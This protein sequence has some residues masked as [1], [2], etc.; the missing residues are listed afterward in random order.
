MEENRVMS[1]SYTFLAREAIKRANRFAHQGRAECV[2]TLHMLLA[3]L[4]EDS[5]V[6][7]TLRIAGINPDNLREKTRRLVTMDSHGAA[8]TTLPFDL[9]LKQALECT[10]EEMRSMNGS[11]ITVDLILIGLLLQDGCE[12]ADVMRDAAVSIE[13]VREVVKEALAIKLVRD[14]NL[15]R[16][17]VPPATRPAVIAGAI[18]ALALW[19]DITSITLEGTPKA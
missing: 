4:D 18:R 19:L 3:L 13:A 1:E 6:I 9:S 15:Y 12:A 10:M 14:G 8:D 16:I 17:T 7:D 11:R 2:K 5:P